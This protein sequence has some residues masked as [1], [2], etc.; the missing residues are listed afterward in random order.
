MGLSEN[1]QEKQESGRKYKIAYGKFKFF[2]TAT[3]LLRGVVSG[4]GGSHVASGEVGGSQVALGGC[5]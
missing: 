4:L 5:I 1:L 2:S 3:I